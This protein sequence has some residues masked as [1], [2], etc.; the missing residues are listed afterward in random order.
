[1]RTHSAPDVGITHWWCYFSENRAD[2]ERVHAVINS[3]GWEMLH[4]GRLQFHN[5]PPHRN[6]PVPHLILASVALCES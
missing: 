3:R 4:W 6:Q 1:M 2:C 5:N